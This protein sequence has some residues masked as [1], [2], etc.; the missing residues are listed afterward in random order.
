[1][2]MHLTMLCFEASH[3]TEELRL[4]AFVSPALFRI[5]FCAPPHPDGP[6]TRA[7]ASSVAVFSAD[8]V[9]LSGGKSLYDSVDVS[10]KWVAGVFLPPKALGRVW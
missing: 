9:A 6:D 5:L 2:Q 10:I 3:R 4:Q 7:E 1:M 8:S